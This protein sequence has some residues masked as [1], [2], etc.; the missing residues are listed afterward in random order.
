M[1]QKAFSL[2]GGAFVVLA[3]TACAPHRSVDEAVPPQ[4]AQ[5][6]SVQSSAS[7]DMN[8]LFVA[9]GNEPFWTIKATGATLTLITP[10]NLRGTE[11]RVGKVIAG[12]KDVQYSGVDGTAPFTLLITR[13][14]CVDTMSGETFVFTSVWSHGN[15]R[16]TGCAASAS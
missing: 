13:E 14:P 4:T 10:E 5:A 15:E 1:S 11:L 16:H 7:G 6:G 12:D 8:R 9:R 3:L 2:L